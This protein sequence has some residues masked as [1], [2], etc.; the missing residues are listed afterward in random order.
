MDVFIRSIPNAHVDNVNG[1][2]VLT[3][4]INNATIGQQIVKRA[5]DI[6]VGFV[7]LIFSKRQ[8]TRLPF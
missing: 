5:F 7:G 3:A 6:F 2:T 1:Y 8:I 4:G